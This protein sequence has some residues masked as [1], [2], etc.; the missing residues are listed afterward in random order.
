[1]EEEVE[2]LKLDMDVWGAV[3]KRAIPP[4]GERSHLRI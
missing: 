1:M 3:Q 2:P 4:A